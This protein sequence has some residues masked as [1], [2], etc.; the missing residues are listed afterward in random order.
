MNR[1]APP[2]PPPPNATA[3]RPRAE[4]L[5]ALRGVTKAYPGGVVAVRD[6]SLAVAPREFVSLLGPSGC[7]KSTVL[8]LIAGLAE[9]T[10]GAVDRAYR[11]T[12]D[13]QPLG[14]VFQE[15]TLLPWAR[16][17]EN[18]YLPLRLRGVGRRQARAS[19]DAA[20]GRVGLADFAAAY[21]RQLSGGMKMRVSVAR[22]TVTRPALLM[23][24]EPFAALDEITRFRLNDDLLSLWAEQAWAALFVTH[25]VFESVFLS[26]R[27]LVMSARPGRIIEEI[28]VPLP[29][30]R[31]GATRTTPE[32]A[33]LCSRVS[34]ALERAMAPAGGDDG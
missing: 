8:R 25:S 32:Y 11:H 5:A 14:C 9:P 27:V 6:A 28:A 33:E 4:P 1:P 19:V 34:A 21:P 2:L 12:A 26:T 20:L 13:D 3:G 10:S 15:P 7:G 16:V 29:F 31:T 24:D 17:W 22:A 23:L 18:V 30:P